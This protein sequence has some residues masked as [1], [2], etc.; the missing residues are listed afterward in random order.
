M[1]QFQQQNCLRLLKLQKKAVRI[2]SH[3]TY[4]AHSEP[5]LKSLNILNVNDIYTFHVAIFMYLCFKQILPK[6][7]SNHFKFNNNVHTYS[8]RSMNDFNIPKLRLAVFHKSIF[9]Q[10]PKIWNNVPPEIKTCQTLK[11]FKRRFK[12]H[13]LSKYTTSFPLNN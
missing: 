2:I 4:L 8:T 1:G 12:Q 10:G 6:S 5:I 13:L 9:A 3:S 11:L 7:L